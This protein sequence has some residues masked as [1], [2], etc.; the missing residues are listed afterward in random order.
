[1]CGPGVF[2][3]PAKKG[4]SGSTIMF[5]T[6]KDLFSYSPLLELFE[7]KICLKINEI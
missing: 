5:I 3:A 6:T 4:G 2:P 1:M 7:Q